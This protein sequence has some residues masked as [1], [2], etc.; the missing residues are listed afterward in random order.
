MTDHPVIH[1]IALRDSLKFFLIQGMKPE[2]AISLITYKNAH[3]LGLQETLGSIEAGKVASLVV[4]N[5]DPLNLGA[6][7]VLVMAEGEVLR[8]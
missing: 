8:S 1:T 6:F 3:I 2:E 4:W 7:P 5:Q